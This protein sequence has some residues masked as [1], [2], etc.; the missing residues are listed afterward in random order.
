MGKPRGT[1]LRTARLTMRPPR[2]GDLDAMVA[3]I[4]DFDIVRW[5]SRVPYPY[6]R[7]D[8]E[9]A[10]RRWGDGSKPVWSIFDESGLVGGIGLIDHLGFWIARQAWGRGYATE[11][12]FSVL[13]AHFSDPQAEPVLA[14]YMQGNEASAIVLLKLGFRDE[15]PCQIASL[16]L[17]RTVPGRSMRL[18][19]P[20]FD[21]ARGLRAAG[22]RSID[23]HR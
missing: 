18:A 10:M 13:G 23:S 17:D 6:T 7:A 11:A 2:E 15:G 12:A 14:Q 22:N 21:A 3:A 4:G 20:D 5:L 8:A 16:A 1:E 19:K 9:E